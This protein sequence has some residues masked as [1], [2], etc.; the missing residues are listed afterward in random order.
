MDRPQHRCCTRSISTDE[1]QGRRLAVKPLQPA[2][3]HTA[4]AMPHPLCQA[5][6]FSPSMTRLAMRRLMAFALTGV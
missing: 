3:S 6:Y 5:R 1:T 4:C 2:T